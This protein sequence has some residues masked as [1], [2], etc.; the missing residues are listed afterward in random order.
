MGLCLLWEINFII[1]VISKRVDKGIILTDSQN[2]VLKF[3]LRKVEFRQV[4]GFSR[5]DKYYF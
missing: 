4:N 5:K 3:I 1:D 2:T